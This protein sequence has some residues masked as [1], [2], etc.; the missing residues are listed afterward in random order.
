[1]WRRW[2]VLVTSSGTGRGHVLVS[3][4]VRET[5]SVVVQGNHDRSIRESE[6]YAHHKM[7][8]AGLEHANAELTTAQIEWLTDVPPQTTFA[9]DQYRLV[10]SHPNPDGM[11][12]YVRPREFAWL[13]EE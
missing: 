1:M 5:Y 8:H 6:R 9:D 7:A 12:T 2:S 4:G 10:H 3:N 13:E 11:G